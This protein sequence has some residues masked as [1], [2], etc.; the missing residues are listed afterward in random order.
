MCKVCCSTEFLVIQ[1]AIELLNIRWK[2]PKEKVNTEQLMNV[3]D[4]MS[5]LTHFRNFIRLLRRNSKSQ[6]NDARWTWRNKNEC[7]ETCHN[8]SD[9][10]REHKLGVPDTK[11]QAHRNPHWNLTRTSRRLFRETPTTL[12]LMCY[13]VKWWSKMWL[14]HLSPYRS[15]KMKI[16][17]TK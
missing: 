15:T 8:T 6:L 1:E 14:N 9:I 3:C 4:A 11:L 7:P 17:Q 13:P 12:K 5:P 10:S 16:V 2:I